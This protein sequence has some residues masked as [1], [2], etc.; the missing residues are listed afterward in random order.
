MF[1][2]AIVG[3]GGTALLLLTLVQPQASAQTR[4]TPPARE[5]HIE[6]EIVTIV[7]GAANPEQISRKPGA[8]LLKVEDRTANPELAITGVEVRDANG[9]PVQNTASPVARQRRRSS[10]MLLHLPPG[11]Y[12]LRAAQS[13]RALC[14][15]H[16][17]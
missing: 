6:T 7:R 10:S 8:F 14:V 13:G 2:T 12:Q 4:A 5:Q 16:I 1:K 17:Q 9:N 3:I 15:I 11:D